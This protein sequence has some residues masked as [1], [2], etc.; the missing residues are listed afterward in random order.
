MAGDKFDFRLNCEPYLLK[1]NT[2]PEGEPKPELP[3]GKPRS[4]FRENNHHA[5][6]QTIQRAVTSSLPFV[7]TFVQ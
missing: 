1:P 6:K 4:V 2:P 7:R 3:E 5:L